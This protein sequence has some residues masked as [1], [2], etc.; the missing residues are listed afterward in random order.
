MNSV[1][2]RR[3]DERG[4]VTAPLNAPSG[5]EH[6]YGNSSPDGAGG[7][8]QYLV[9]SKSTPERKDVLGTQMQKRTGA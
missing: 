3:D 1:V 6:R 7:A 5:Y 8:D 4:C 9:S 2:E